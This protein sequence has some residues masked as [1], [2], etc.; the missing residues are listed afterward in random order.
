MVSEWDAVLMPVS[1]F[2]HICRMSEGL[3]KEKEEME[4]LKLEN[5]RV[6][7]GDVNDMSR[8]LHD[9]L[10]SDVHHEIILNSIKTYE[11]DDELY[12]EAD[13]T[14]GEHVKLP[15]WPFAIRSLEKRSGDNATGHELMT[16]GQILNSMN[17]YWGLHKDKRKCYATVRGDKILGVGSEQYESIS[18]EEIVEAV[19]DWM[20]D[21]HPNAWIFKDG[22]YTHQLTSASFEIT[23]AI[24]PGYKA[25]WRK[26]GLPQSLLDQSH[27][28]VRVL[29]DDT[30]GCAAKAIVGM[31]VG[32]TNFLLGNP[33]EIAHRAGH[34]GIEAFKTEL[35]KV[36]IS[37]KDELDSLA[38][39][40]GINLL[41]PTNAGI[42]ALKKAKIDKI[43]KKACKELIDDMLFG[44]TE[45][46][47]I[48]YLFLHGITGTPNG[49]KL[50][51]ER[52]LRVTTALRTLLKED[53]KK[54][55]VP[56]ASL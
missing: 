21:R 1:F 53:W 5:A 47:Y 15:L 30:A 7:F 56:S 12:L 40:M 23:D 41:H 51:G 8:Y 49:S 17:N 2:G 38:K 55:D 29:T 28:T 19:T 3:K 24:S 16:N 39:L 11:E 27:I 46:A 31:N 48:V 22:Y 13:T 45:S 32:G 52:Q 43:S 34:G 18:Q 25:A 33:I 37:I 10:E 20:E 44:S 9:M 42:M 14:N 50:S 6:D 35:N 26:T 36:D 54:L 4:N